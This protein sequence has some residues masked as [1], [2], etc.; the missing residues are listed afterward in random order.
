MIKLFFGVFFLIVIAGIIIININS[1]NKSYI[2]MNGVS[3]S[4]ESYKAIQ[5]QFS[6]YKH[7]SVCNLDN[8]NCIFLT[9]IP[10]GP[11][12]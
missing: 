5:E 12:S 1:M 7:V 6:E 9:K 8:K 11:N 2:E 4:K 3:I 10:D